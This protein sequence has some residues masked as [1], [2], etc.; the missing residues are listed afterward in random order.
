MHFLML[1]HMSFMVRAG[2]WHSKPN[3]FKI[4]KKSQIEK[5][6]Y[7]QT[8]DNK[9]SFETSDKLYWMQHRERQRG[10]YTFGHLRCK[11][12]PNGILEA[13]PGL[14]TT[15]G[16]HESKHSVCSQIKQGH[17]SSILIF[18]SNKTY[19]SRVWETSATVFTLKSCSYQA[20]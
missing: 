19:V 15:P 20:N 10:L 8:S 5:E 16:G 11:H 18:T 7:K 2:V 9:T 3:V 14:W 13:F 17:Y 1:S 12:Q 6:Q 4:I